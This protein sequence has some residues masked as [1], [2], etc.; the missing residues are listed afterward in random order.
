M[1]NVKGISFKT[2]KELKEDFYATLIPFVLEIIE[3][4]EKVKEE[5]VR[6]LLEKK[7]RI[8]VSSEV[9]DS[10][11]K[12]MTKRKLIERDNKH[13]EST[14]RGRSEHSKLREKMKINEFDAEEYERKIEKMKNDE[15]RMLVRH[16]RAVSSVIVYAVTFTAVVIMFVKFPD[17]YQKVISFA[18]ATAVGLG[19]AKIDFGDIFKPRIVRKVNERYRDYFRKIDKINS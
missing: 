19:A 6:E 7:Y 1:A 13:I 16:A 15:I 18:I 11:F 8:E 17:T 5:D 4:K 9:L 2:T 14:H 12:L 3:R 10:V